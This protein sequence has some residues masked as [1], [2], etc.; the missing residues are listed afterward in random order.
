M[1]AAEF[2]AQAMAS[3]TVRIKEI[4]AAVDFA[5]YFYTSGAMLQVRNYNRSVLLSAVVWRGLC[6]CK[7]ERFS[8]ITVQIYPASKG[9]DVLDS[10][11]HSS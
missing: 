11:N 5:R 6:S 9:S 10:F 7:L 3:L 1:L 2:Y 4:R 8:I